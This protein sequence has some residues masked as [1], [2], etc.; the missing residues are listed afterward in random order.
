MSDERLLLIT[1]CVAVDNRSI[2]KLLR[3][4]HRGRRS[5]PHRGRS[6]ECWLI[7][8]L[9]RIPYLAPQNA[10]HDWNTGSNGFLYA[11]WGL[12]WVDAVLAYLIAFGVIY[13]ILGQKTKD[14]AKVVPIWIIPVVALIASSTCGGLMGDA[15]MPHSHTL[16]LVSS[17]FAL[18]MVIIGLSFTTMISWSFLLRLFLHGAP[19]ASAVLATFN[20]LTPLGQ[21]GFSLLVN[22]A[23]LSRLIPV[24]ASSSGDDFPQSMLSGQMFFSICF[25]FS[26]ILWC[27]GLAWIMVSVFSI[28]RR[29]NKLP[30]F[31]IVQWCIV[32]PNGVFALC[33]VQLGNVLESRF[34]KGF[35]AA[36]SII[37]FIMWTGLMIRSVPA[38]IDGTMFLPPVTREPGRKKHHHHHHHKEGA[39]VSEKHA[40]PTLGHAHDHDDGATLCDSDRATVRP[41]DPE[42]PPPPTETTP[43]PVYPL[44]SAQA[45]PPAPGTKSTHSPPPVPADPAMP[46]DQVMVQNAW[47]SKLG[48]RRGMLSRRSS[49]AA[50]LSSLVTT[51]M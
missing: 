36:W 40:L 50:G 26:Y 44:P 18:T 47:S 31:T 43:P 33:S 27:M 6:S 21:G 30:Q 15:L 29:A 14:L 37:V 35:G 38:F 3:W 32:F 5:R 42:T 24:R 48:P 12:W 20:T 45:V 19:D 34:Y 25:C 51:K 23:N 49:R 41:H 13:F 9:V 4:F 7:A 17:A 1:G 28:A 2:T 11:L 22:G 8:F 16:A 46:A 10:N 39:L